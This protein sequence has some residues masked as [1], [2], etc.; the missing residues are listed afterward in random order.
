MPSEKSFFWLAIIGI[1]LI[2][3]GSEFLLFIGWTGGV[4]IVAGSVFLVIRLAGCLN[5]VEEW[6]EKRGIKSEK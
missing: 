5:W 3:A 2:M 6:F 4:I 1:T